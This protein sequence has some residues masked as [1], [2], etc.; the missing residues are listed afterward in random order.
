M[1]DDL[2]TST[3]SSTIEPDISASLVNVP[4][5]CYVHAFNDDQQPRPSSD[6]VN[7]PTSQAGLRAQQVR[8]V[9]KERRYIPQRL[10]EVN[11]SYESSLKRF[12]ELV[13]FDVVGVGE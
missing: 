2:N 4:P 12:L 13:S 3:C 10:T 5:V 11:L 7:L 1:D 9:R 8:N 6:P